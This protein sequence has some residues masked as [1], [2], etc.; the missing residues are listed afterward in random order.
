MMG[1]FPDLKEV[2]QPQ[3]QQ[4]ADA[5]HQAG[6]QRPDGW[7]Q[8]PEAGEGHPPDEAGEEQHQDA[9]LEPRRVHECQH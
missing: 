7:G 5:P 4:A 3:G 9:V 8:R 2:I 1:S 6:Q